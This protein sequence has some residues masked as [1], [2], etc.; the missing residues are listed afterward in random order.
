[1]L[2]SPVKQG[3]GVKARCSCPAA[4]VPATLPPPTPPTGLTRARPGKRRASATVRIDGADVAPIVSDAPTFTSQTTLF[5][6]DQ[7][8]AG[9]HLLEIVHTGPPGAPL[10]LDA[11]QAASISAPPP[12]EVL[13]RIESDD[14]D[15]TYSGDWFTWVHPSQSEGTAA[16]GRGS[17]TAM[18]PFSGTRLRLIAQAGPDR[19]RVDVRVDAVLVATVDTWAPSYA[20]R[21]IVLDLADLVDG[22]HE[23]ELVVNGAH[24]DAIGDPALVLD[25][26]E[27]NRGLQPPLVRIEDDDPRMIRTGNWSTWSHPSQSGGS[28]AVARGLGTSMTVRFRGTSI[29]WIGQRGPDRAIGLV[30]I[31]GAHV[32]TVDTHHGS[33]ESQRVLFSRNGLTDAVHTLTITFGG[34]NPL[35]DLA[36]GTAS[37]LVDALEAEGFD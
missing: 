9:A 26:V 6:T 1:M 32:T 3:P 36:P 22:H 35:A 16:V 29:R 31:D 13:E 24:P 8:A 34:V 11:L 2:L 33:F 27:A 19:A 20:S 5:S 21:Q 28:A 18:L 17:A 12:I 37:L 15:W 25:A 7:L 23:L 4:G 30:A 10:V 14:P